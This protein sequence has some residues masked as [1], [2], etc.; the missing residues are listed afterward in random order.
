M[1]VTGHGAGTS[2]ITFVA[3][4][5]ALEV[6]VLALQL[7]LCLVEL[8]LPCL[9]S[10]S[11]GG[12]SHEGS[13]ATGVCLGCSVGRGVLRGEESEASETWPS[14]TYATSAM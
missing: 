4:N 2:S 11:W 12:Y 8:P 14:E 1:Y 13:D 5:F 9:Q 3:R 7:V 10:P 6:L